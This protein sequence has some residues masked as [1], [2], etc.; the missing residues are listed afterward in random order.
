MVTYITAQYRHVVVC[1]GLYPVQS[2]SLHGVTLQD[3]LKA[4]CSLL[5]RRKAVERLCITSY[6]M[7]VHVIL[8]Y[9]PPGAG[10]RRKGLVN[11]LASLV[12]SPTPS[13][14]SLLSTV[15]RTK[16]RR[17]AGRGTGNEAI[18]RT[19]EYKQ[20]SPSRTHFR[21]HVAL[22]CHCVHRSDKNYPLPQ[23]T[24][25]G[26]PGSLFWNGVLPSVKLG[27]GSNNF[28][29]NNN[30]FSLRLRPQ[31]VQRRRDRHWQSLHFPRRLIDFRKRSIGSR[32]LTVQPENNTRVY[33]AN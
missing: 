17:K 21:L 24:V 1:S 19:L 29:P 28:R 9:P 18:C 7:T 3:A 12:P 5:S 32:K 16:Q 2:Q 31:N 26:H 33:H 10:G 8:S 13:F 20:E 23:S 4:Q 27:C 22:Y 11:N 14:S 30:S 15:K 6:E 25:A